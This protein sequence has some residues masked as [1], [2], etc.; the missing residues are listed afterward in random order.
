MAYCIAGNT[1]TEL[2]QARNDQQG[3]SKNFVITLVFLERPRVL[4]GDRTE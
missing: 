4:C 3:K 2:D 1:A